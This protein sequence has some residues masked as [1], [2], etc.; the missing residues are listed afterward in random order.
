MLSVVWSVRAR[1]LPAADPQLLDLWKDGLTS[2]LPLGVAGAV[3]IDRRPD[4]PFGWLLGIGA[5]GQALVV[6]LHAPALLAVEHGNTSALPR[7]GLATS[8]LWFVPEMV[9][10]L[11]NL[12]FPSGG[13]QSR[14]ARA[15]E[16]AILTG[17]VLVVLG[18]LFG[19]TSLNPELDARAARVVPHLEHPLTGGTVVGKI[20][21]ALV[22]FAPIVAFLGVLA[23]LGVLVRWRRAVGVERQQLRWR[24]A[25]VVMAIAL[26]PVS[27]AGS[28]NFLNRLDVPFFV[29]T[30]AIPVLR[31]R[32]WSIDTIVRR[33]VAYAGVIAVLVGAYA[34]VVAAGSALMSER[35]GAMV[36]AVAIAVAFA[37]LPRPHATARRPLVLRR[38]DGPVPCVERPGAPFGACRT[39]RR[40]V[41]HS[42]RG[43]DVVAVSVCCGRTAGW[44]G[45]CRKREADACRGAVAVDLRA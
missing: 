33:S 30:L 34:A 8:G 10:G 27:V 26:F 40:L 45:D 3:L 28:V 16:V 1:E 2:I 19:A 18:S 39:D 43:R 6:A 13:L 4:L 32:L 41:G 7:W 9:K 36:A 37:P 38:S 21:D 31:Y 42:R 25:G 29:V 23:G 12:R 20:G 17:T 44:H 5:V 22:G 35:I 15:L 24:A 14:R 11:V